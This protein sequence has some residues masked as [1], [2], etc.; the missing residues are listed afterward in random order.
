MLS[1]KNCLY[2]PWFPGDKNQVADSL[3]RDFH[4]SNNELAQMITSFIPEQVP[5]G[6][7][8]CGRNN[9]QE[10]SSHMV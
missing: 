6:F 3:P 7:Q 1:C 4:L 10:A 8:M 9:K 2:S 5:F